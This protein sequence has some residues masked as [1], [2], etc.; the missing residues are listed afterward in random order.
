MKV[1]PEI[2]PE[3]RRGRAEW[4]REKLA[5]LPKIEGPDYIT[6][7]KRFHEAVTALGEELST[8]PD[9]PRLRDEWNGASVTMLGLRSTSTSG[10]HGALTNWCARAEGEIRR[11]AE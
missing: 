3:F 2:L 9:T 8:A 7:R 6:S 10:L 4:L 11:A 1:K 5:A